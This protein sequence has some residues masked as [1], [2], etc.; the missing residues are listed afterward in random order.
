M[1]GDVCFH[2][3]F[4]CED[5]EEVQVN[6]RWLFEE[7]FT[8]LILLIFRRCRRLSI[9]PLGLKYGWK[10][11]PQPGRR[12]RCWHLMG[13]KSGPGPKTARRWDFVNSWSL[14]RILKVILFLDLILKYYW[15]SGVIIQII[16]ENVK[17]LQYLIGWR[18]EEHHVSSEFR[19]SG[20]R[21]SKHQRLWLERKIGWNWTVSMLSVGMGWSKCSSYISCITSYVQVTALVSNVH[22]KDNDA[23]QGGVDDMTKL[24]YLHEP[25][26]LYNLATRYELDEI[27][28]SLIWTCLEYHTLWRYQCCDCT[29]KWILNPTKICGDL[30]FQRYTDVLVEFVTW[31]MFF[32][33]PVC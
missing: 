28:V 33:E 31:T 15:L 14:L 6:M 5:S 27:Y 32:S 8:A 29:C 9:L 16:E 13:N 3:C 11:P 20:A 4:L 18:R 19:G 1:P 12:L 30:G 25:G 2:D 21:K 24:A 17:R 10:T 26:V 23:Q 22:P 7:L